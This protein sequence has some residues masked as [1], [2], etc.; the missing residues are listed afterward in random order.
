MA[1]AAKLM[2]PR[3]TLKMYPRPDTYYRNK[4]SLDFDMMR[5]KIMVE[6]KGST[7]E[8]IAIWGAHILCGFVMGVV[9][10]LLSLAEDQLT[11]M[12]CGIT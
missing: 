8:S 3:N 4:A 6:R 10:F 9:S 2:N 5:T 7:S 1:G 12:R 11:L